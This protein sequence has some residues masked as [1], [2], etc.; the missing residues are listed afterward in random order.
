MTNIIR[1]IKN[2][3]KPMLEKFFLNLRKRMELII[4]N[5]GGHRMNIINFITIYN[6][7]FYSLS[8]GMLLFKQ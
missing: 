5:E 4:S 1:K 6:F 2:I 3:K 8:N 7:R